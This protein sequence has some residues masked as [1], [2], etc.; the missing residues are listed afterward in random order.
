MG[1]GPA[2]HNEKDMQWLDAIERVLAE[3]D[4]ALRYT[5][6]AE[7]IVSKGYR[8]KVG[9]TPVD[10]VAATLSTSLRDANTPFLR[11]STGV[12]MLKEMSG[13]QKRE[14]AEKTEA[15]D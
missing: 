8:K 2:G 4:G 15:I 9:S 6:I 14:Q 7:Q 10:T 13:K 12:Y 11:V 3:S 5:E 1:R